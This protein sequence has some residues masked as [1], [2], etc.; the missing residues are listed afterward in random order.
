MGIVTRM[1]RDVLP[2]GATITATD[3]NAPMMAVAKRKF[4]REESVEFRVADAAELSFADGAFDVALCQFG[5][6]F[7]TEKANS[8]PSWS[9]TTQ[10]RFVIARHDLSAP[11]PAL[12]S[13][14]RGGA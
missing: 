6:L 7:L 4:G 10:N 13:Q 1:L 9:V 11:V 5:D 12:R 2:A 3:L 8:P 14:E